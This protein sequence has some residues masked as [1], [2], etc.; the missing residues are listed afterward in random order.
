[1]AANNTIVKASN[2]T[3]AIYG[4]KKCA[5]VGLKNRVMTEGRGL[6][7][8]NDIMRALNPD[9]DEVYKF[10]VVSKLED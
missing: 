2:D 10:L 7:V 6:E 8:L 3:G 5:A 9:S 4:V 1:M